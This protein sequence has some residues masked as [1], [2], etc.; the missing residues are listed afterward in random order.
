MSSS[1]CPM[2]PCVYQYNFE[3]KLHTTTSNSFTISHRGRAEGGGRCGHPRHGVRGPRQPRRGQPRALVQARQLRR[4][5]RARPRVLPPHR[6]VRGAAV[7]AV[8]S[9][10]GRA[11]VCRISGRPRGPGDQVVHQPGQSLLAAGG[12]AGGWAGQWRY[13]TR[14]YF[15]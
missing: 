4:E 5:A 8:T 6:A 1:N 14:R 10:A 15:C 12:G 9:V 7:S 11:A 3:V 2:H 13:R